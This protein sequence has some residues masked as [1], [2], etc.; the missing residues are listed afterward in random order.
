MVAVRGYDPSGAR[1]SEN[2]HESDLMAGWRSTA[3][4]QKLRA[5]TLRAE[6]LCR[7]CRARGRIMAAVEVDHIVPVAMGGAK[8]DRANLQPLCE[9]CHKEKTGRDQGRIAAEQ[10]GDPWSCRH[11]Y[12]VGQCPIDKDCGRESEKGVSL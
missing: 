5:A 9:P 2:G 6:P 7:G 3:R 11:G 4:W 1:L 12:P 8:W 10:R